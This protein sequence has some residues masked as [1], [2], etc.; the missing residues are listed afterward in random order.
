[1]TCRPL[2]I[3]SG[4]LFILI[5]LWP[6]TFFKHGYD[7]YQKLLLSTAVHLVTIS[8]RIKQVTKTKTSRPLFIRSGFLFI[9]IA[10]WPLTFFKHGYDGYQK[11]LLS[12]AVH[13]VTISPRIKQVT[14]LRVRE[15][16]IV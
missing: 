5:A 15:T 3:R 2:F 1:M 16:T 14:L 11:L 13:L 7:G 9:L 8:L 10:L 4:F 6:L 12:T